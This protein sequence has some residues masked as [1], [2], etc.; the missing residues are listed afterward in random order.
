MTKKLDHFENLV[1]DKL[2]QQEFDFDPSGWDKLQKELHPKKPFFKNPKFYGLT[3]MVAVIIITGL[4]YLPESKTST[5]NKDNT[6]LSNNIQ[7]ENNVIEGSISNEVISSKND[8]ETKNDLSSS[9]DVDHFVS[10]DNLNKSTNNNS[11]SENSQSQ[12][13]SETKS[14]SNKVSNNLTETNEVNNNV[15]NLPIDSISE[16][17]E[18]L[19][20]ND[21]IAAF[22][23]NKTDGCLGETFVFNAIEQENVIYTWSFG[24]GESSKEIT[25]THTFNRPGKYEVSLIATNNMYNISD[26]SDVQIITVLPTPSTDFEYEIYTENGIPY[27]LFTSEEHSS[28]IEWNFGDNETSTAINPDHVYRKKGTY[29]VTVKVENEFGCSVKKSQ[30]VYI[31]KDYN[32]LAPNSFT[33]NGDGINDFFIPAALEL[34]AESFT[35]TIYGNNGLIYETQNISEPWDGTNQRT[36]MMSLPGNYFWVVKLT[37]KEG[38]T[39]QY[40]GAILLLK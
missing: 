36:G 20:I 18:T 25:P 22:Y 14:L 15:A 17:E 38:K 39:E 29:V 11:N 10:S 3:G 6:Q 37:T 2:N 26:K 34:V 9:K 16:N 32:L 21:P 8:V 27:T 5:K 7:K 23:V 4:Y 12:T 19:E 24:D 40:K 28:K 31:D 35:M 30:Q 33:P 1:K 13:K